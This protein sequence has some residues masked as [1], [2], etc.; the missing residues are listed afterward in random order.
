MTEVIGK[1]RISC[2]KSYERI[3]HGKLDKF[4]EEGMKMFGIT[5]KH[6]FINKMKDAYLNQIEKDAFKKLFK[7]YGVTEILWEDVN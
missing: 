4:H 7:K 1:E 6:N 3:E 5:A 2:W